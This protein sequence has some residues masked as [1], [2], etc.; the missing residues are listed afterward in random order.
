MHDFPPP[1]N[2]LHPFATL[3]PIRSKKSI[4][5]QFNLTEY[6]WWPVIFRVSSAWRNI[7]PFY[8]IVQVMLS[9]TCREEWACVQL[10]LNRLTMVHFRHK[11]KGV[12]SA[13]VDEWR[14]EGVHCRGCQCCSPVLQWHQQPG[15]RCFS[16]CSSCCKHLPAFIRCSGQV[17]R[18]TRGGL[19]MHVWKGLP[20]HSRLSEIRSVW[21]P[22][23]PG[24]CPG[25]FLVL[26]FQVTVNY[27]LK[28]R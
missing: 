11:E 5:S 23:W 19:K 18:S 6:H 26:L 12:V 3:P 10:S 22:F 17:S 4:R 2:L 28:K 9:A 8:R 14:L 25:T 21:E 7:G 20:A 1:T 16:G 24:N 27:L 13:T 15:W